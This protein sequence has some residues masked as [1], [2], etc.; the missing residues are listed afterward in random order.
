MKRRDGGRSTLA[1]LGWLLT[2][3]ALLARPGFD[4]GRNAAGWLAESTGVT[5][6]P[7]AG[8]YWVR[9]RGIADPA[10]ATA[11]AE[12][13]KR[14]TTLRGRGEKVCV[15]LFVG[16]RQ[17][18]SG[19]RPGAYRRFPLDVR[20]AYAWARALGEAYGPFVDAWELDNEPDIGWA[21]ENP[22]NFA[23][24]LKA[25][26][27]GFHDGARV[28]A[29]TLAPE[30]RRRSLGSSFHKVTAY[31]APTGT[32]A[33]R[34]P[35]M[36]R[37][38]MGSMA[39]PPGPYF[40][41]LLRNEALAYTDGFNFHYYGYSE[42]FSGVYRQFES[43]ITRFALG[44]N[45]AR[46][47]VERRELPI[48]ITEYGYGLLNADNRGTV[49]GRVGQWRWF[50]DVA[51]Q[52]RA[53]GIEAPMAFFLPPYLEH[54]ANEFG[55]TATELPSFAPGDFAA[56]SAPTWMRW[57]GHRW[58]N[59]AITPALAWLMDDA[60]RRASSSRSWT[61]KV[62][63][64]S[65][66]VLD[67][68]ALD[69]AVPVKSYGG[70]LLT[71]PASEGRLAGT[72]EV[73]G[74]N[75]S[76]RPVSGR[77]AFSEGLEV[78]GVGG[79]ARAPFT[80]E[81]GER[82][83]WRLIVSVAGEAFLKSPCEVKIMADD[84]SCAALM[85]T[86]LYPNA[87]AMRELLVQSFDFDATANRPNAARALSRPLA[88]EEPK[89]GEAGRWLTTGG[90]AIAE[91]A[92][93]GTWTFGITQ[94]AAVAQRKVT[95]ELPLPSGFNFPSMGMLNLEYRRL[96]PERVPA[97]GTTTDMLDVG[98]RTANGN[99]YYVW[100]RLE[101]ATAWRRY[102]QIKENFSMAFYGRAALPWRFVDNEPVSLVLTF[103]PKTLP[104]TYEIRGLRIVKYE[105]GG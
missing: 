95:A 31:L 41:A 99:L 76:Q 101:A 61:L 74:Y 1:F 96:G 69:N 83:V 42:D 90:V 47:Q 85:S 89:P 102:G 24:Y 29:T 86:A 77:L 15:Q 72:V 9:L 10:D 44:E 84:G 39:L 62:P 80:L 35:T 54:G 67:I 100:P 11:L 87:S 66:V 2:A 82:R 5:E 91:D 18:K 75:F 28:A 36:A 38:T 8:P 55:L 33:H 105:K 94:F 98:F 3:G 13:Q 22:E 32:A 81:P 20:E 60:T 6:V 46:G 79:D 52:T 104:A 56:T 70:Y 51:N 71:R 30:K 68:V 97:E 7:W 58:N 12:E 92:T 49:A 53:L 21:P 64:A 45:R 40:Q 14:L 59:Q 88:S 65:P 43:A 37:V 48:F 16:A 73:I 50:K 63:A 26:Y 103:H 34:Q 23:A 78:T 25:C 57:L 17:W 27:L 19:V 4:T 93:S